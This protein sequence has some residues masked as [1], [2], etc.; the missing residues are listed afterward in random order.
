[1]PRKPVAGKRKASTQDAPPR[2]YWITRK[3]QLDGLANAVR[4]DILDRLVAM[5]PM[6]VKDLSASLGR[7]ST[8]IYHHLELLES[9]ELVR[10]TNASGGRG[11]PASLYQAAGQLIRAAR[12]PVKPE[13][14]A[15]AAKIARVVA[16]QAAKD[17]KD[18]F[19]VDGWQLEGPGRNHWQFR[20]IARPSPQRLAK[21]NALM[22]TLGELIWTPDPSP[23]KQ[24]ISFAWFLSPLQANRRLRR[25]GKVPTRKRTKRISN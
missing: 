12:A 6:S 25:P 24:L 8:A 3:D 13:N 4:L 21:I 14:R 18:G 15:P 16:A 2:V 23:G 10:K 19:A 22:D 5:G 1:M 7:R 17:Y 11:R 20:S 9:L